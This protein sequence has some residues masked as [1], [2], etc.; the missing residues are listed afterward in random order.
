MSLEISFECKTSIPTLKMIHFLTYMLFMRRFQP[1]PA[2]QWTWS[3][4]IVLNMYLCPYVWKR[5]STVQSTFSLFPVLSP[6]RIL[7]PLCCYKMCHQAQTQETQSHDSQS[8][9]HMNPQ[10]GHAGPLEQVKL[11]TQNSSR[12]IF[13]YISGSEEVLDGSEWLLNW[14]LLDFILTPICI[15]TL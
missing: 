14:H 11:I 4:K 8:S 5:E 12:V 2:V 7:C 3:N 15:D 13:G 9:A 1:H 10:Q 6:G